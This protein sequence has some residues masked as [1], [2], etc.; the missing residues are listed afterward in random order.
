L[1]L[2]A[3][4]ICIKIEFS[5]TRLYNGL[6][7]R[8]ERAMVRKVLFTLVVASLVATISLGQEDP[9]PKLQDLLLTQEELQEV[10][11]EVW[12][13]KTVGKLDPEP[14]GSTTAV[15][16]FVDTNT[17]TELVIGLLE[18]QDLERAVLF[19]DALL[20][21]EQIL[22]VRD[23]R[24]EAQEDP[25]LLELLPERLVKETERLFLIE[26]ENGLQ[27]LLL[28]RKTL[29]AFLRIPKGA[30]EEAQLFQVADLQLGKILGFC[31]SL[32]EE[33]RPAYC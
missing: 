4:S 1:K 11:G 8:K 19:F 9:T 20:Q 6:P 25:S 23:L 33:E 5:G 12:V 10:L 21:A 17:D 3:S 30:L 24:A 16:T 26:L 32:A 13:I 28:Q 15:A 22:G 29:I 2:L 7:E 14:E 31:E 18:F 27:Q